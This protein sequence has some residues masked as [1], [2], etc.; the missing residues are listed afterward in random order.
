[1]D[2]F[3]TDAKGELLKYNTV[4]SAF[5]AGFE[6][7]GLSWRSTHI[8]RHSYAT[9]ALMATNSISAVQATL[10]HTSSRMTEKYAKAV[11]LMDRGV[12]EKTAKGFDIFSK[13]KV[14]E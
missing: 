5:N 2:W 1:M 7:L 14:S 3:F 4:Q 11:V 8:L 6:A 13:R 10:G 9:A 12:A